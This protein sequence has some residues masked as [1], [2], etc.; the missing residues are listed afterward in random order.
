MTSNVSN[1]IKWNKIQELEKELQKHVPTVL[2]LVLP[3]YEK[4]YDEQFYRKL[5][6]R[7]IWILANKLYDIATEKCCCYD[8]Y[9][10][11]YYNQLK[12]WEEVINEVTTYID[13][14]DYERY[15]QKG[16]FIVGEIKQKNYEYAIE[17]RDQL[18]RIHDYLNS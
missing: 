9:H 7:E 8:S 16:S 6:K 1:D 10:Y 3:P 15:Q 13:I 14:T 17:K 18:W 5:A 4:G 2:D 11:S 12:D